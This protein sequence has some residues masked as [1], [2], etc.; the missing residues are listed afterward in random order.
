M[1]NSSNGLIKLTETLISV[2]RR[3]RIPLYSCRKSKHVYK[4]YQHVAVVCLMK[5]FRLHYRSVIELLEIT[6]ELQRII[7]LNRLPHYT[8]IHKF[9]RR[10][11][12][13]KM[14]LILGQT[15]RLFGIT[16]STIAVDSTGFSSNYASRY[17]M[18]IRYR[19]ENGVWNR[20]YMK[21]TLTVDT[22][23]QVVISDLPTDEH[24]NDYPYFVPALNRT[25]RKVRIRTVIA[26]R[27]Y[28]SESNNRF[29]RYR[30]RAN[31]DIR[32]RTRRRRKRFWG[33]LRKESVKDFDW[34]TYMK[35]NIVESVFSVIKRRL[36]DTL[37]SRSLRLRKK[38]LKVMCI[39]YNIN[40]YVRCFCFVWM[41]STRPFKL[42]FLNPLETN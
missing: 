16:E 10:F 37:Y 17:Y 40:R 33:R 27:G 29:V 19:Q 20:S 9:F 13:T 41:F 35:R 14:E 34:E 30:L 32:V 42:N 23:R 15:V 7:G 36:G 38:E 3:S 24:G 39:V 22:D 8:T 25:K 4:Q 11:S 2:C 12:L 5:Q 26:D 28:D 31:N 6:P 21:Q 18:M 1:K